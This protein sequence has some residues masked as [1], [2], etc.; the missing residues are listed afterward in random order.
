MTCVPPDNKN[1]TNFVKQN[2]IQN[3]VKRAKSISTIYKTEGL[4]SPSTTTAS[5][6]ISTVTPPEDVRFQK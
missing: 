2:L 6:A 4:K 5:A 3:K 1:Y